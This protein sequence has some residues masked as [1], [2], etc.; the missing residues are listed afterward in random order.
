MKF[1]ILIL[2][3]YILF[4]YH[5][6]L[7]K[8]SLIDSINQINPETDNI[9]L[10]HSS[11]CSYTQKVIDFYETTHDKYF[12]D[13]TTLNFYKIDMS[14]AAAASF[15]QTLFNIKALPSIIFVKK[16]NLQF[17][18]DLDPTLQF[19]FDLDPTPEDLRFFI[20][21]HQNQNIPLYKTSKRLDDSFNPHYLAFIGDEL[22]HQNAYNIFKQT[23]FNNEILPCARLSNLDDRNEKSYQEALLNQI[24]LKQYV[25]QLLSQQNIQNKEA[26]VNFDNQFLMNLEDFKKNVSTSP[27]NQKDSHFN[28][29]ELDEMN[30]ILTNSS[31]FNEV[32][33]NTPPS[34][35]LNSQLDLTKEALF[36]YKNVQYGKTVFFYL[37]HTDSTDIE[38]QFK[39]FIKTYTQSN[40]QFKFSHRLRKHMTENESVG[41]VL[42]AKKRFYSSNFYI[43]YFV[44]QT[45]D[46]KRKIKYDTDYLSG[47]DF[48]D[49]SI[50]FIIDPEDNNMNKQL[51]NFIGL[52]DDK[53][54]AIYTFRFSKNKDYL[55]KSRFKH[56]E[57]YYT[58]LLFDHI[59][60]MHR[61]MFEGGVQMREVTQEKDEYS[62]NIM[63]L[64]NFSYGKLLETRIHEKRL[65]LIEFTTSY[66]RECLK[67]NALI[68]KIS[69][70]LKTSHGY[71]LIY[72]RLDVF[73][74]DFEK[75]PGEQVPFLRIYKTENQPR[76]YLEINNDFSEE[77]LLQVIENYTFK[78]DTD[79]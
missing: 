11:L 17:K 21:K 76:E 30:N 53:V 29:H 45:Q 6:S 77:K 19:K 10:F 79:L 35:Q 34:Q 78:Y 33:F 59:R 18:F 38:T 31:I 32:L 3:L 62:Q 25:H 69:N 63:I 20:E 7:A 51:A 4:T 68:N 49:A 65:I 16:S 22:I 24:A 36:M 61:S 67:L 54:P 57:R 60:A 70:T 41:V 5:V 15:P 48:I 27:E 28:Q 12:K 72:T 23:C 37:N 13:T 2:A 58:N 42:F 55:E 39:N 43:Q 74:N 44:N 64:N 66:C 1:N 50:F 56:I 71:R 8:I 26:I 75:L 46:L 9:F 73:E 52:E 40:I 14:I 47:K